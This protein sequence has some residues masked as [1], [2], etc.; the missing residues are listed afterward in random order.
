MLRTV[1][2]FQR[3]KKPVYYEASQF[4]LSVKYYWDN[5]FKGHRMGQ[6][7]YIACTG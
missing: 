5:Q 6:E 1:P 7:E 2:E 4:V 3:Q